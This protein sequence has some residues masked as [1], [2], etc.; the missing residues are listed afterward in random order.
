MNSHRI[1]K[2]DSYRIGEAS[3]TIREFHLTNL[4][5]SP[6]INSLINEKII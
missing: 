3:E 1:E 5:R 4:I 2:H 6:L